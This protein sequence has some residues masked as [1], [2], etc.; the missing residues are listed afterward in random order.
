MTVLA[1]L[2]ATLLSIAA[3]A[4]LAATDA[5]RRRVFG[6]A[7]FPGR[8]HVWPALAVTFLPAPAL[9]AF[10]NSAGLIV[11]LG[12]ITVA[13]WGVAALTPTQARRLHTGVGSA[14][15]RVG[16]GLSVTAKRSFSR[17]IAAGSRLADIAQMPDRIATL[18]ARVVALEAELKHAGGRPKHPRLVQLSGQHEGTPHVGADEPSDQ[19][20][21]ARGPSAAP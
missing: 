10:G 1:T 14:A 9:L 15:G 7:P 16:R 19:G 21:A 18:E 11:W 6:Y 3:L 13:G 2:V 17:A 8:R 20:A 12:A 4:Y 5:K